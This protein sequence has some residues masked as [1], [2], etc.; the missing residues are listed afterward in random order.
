MTRAATIVSQLSK[1]HKKAYAT[2][3]LNPKLYT[4]L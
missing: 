2:K 1:A 3:K 4:K